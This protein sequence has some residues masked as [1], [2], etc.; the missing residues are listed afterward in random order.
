MITQTD[1]KDSLP[2]TTSPVQVPG[3]SASV[4]IYRDRYGI[5]HVQANTV[6]DAF[7]G[8]GFATAQDRL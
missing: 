2:D 7:W 8:Q 5:P 1:L 6:E 4:E 3:L